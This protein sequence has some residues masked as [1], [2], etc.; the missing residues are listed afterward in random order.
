MAELTTSGEG[1]AGVEECDREWAEE[2][3]ANDLVVVSPQWG[4]GWTR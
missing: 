3:N 4:L 1:E 2:R